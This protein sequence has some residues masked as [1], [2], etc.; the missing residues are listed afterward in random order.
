M[1]KEFQGR[2]DMI[3]L[4]Q[5]NIE[6]L[7]TLIYFLGGDFFTIHPKKENAGRIIFQ[8]PTAQ[9]LFYI[10]CDYVKEIKEI[11]TKLNKAMKVN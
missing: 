10:I 6:K 4:L 11:S 5:E 8:Y 1:Q 3:Q 2:E 7:D 9:I